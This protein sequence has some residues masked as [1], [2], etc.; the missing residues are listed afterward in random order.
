MGDSNNENVLFCCFGTGLLTVRGGIFLMSGGIVGCVT[1][2][3]W[4]T[5]GLP[6]PAVALGESRRTGTARSPSSVACSGSRWQP[7]PPS[8]T[9]ESALWVF[10]CGCE[11][12]SSE[13]KGDG[14]ML[15][16]LSLGMIGGLESST[17]V[18]VS[19]VS[20]S[21]QCPSLSPSLTLGPATLF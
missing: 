14:S 15:I 12:L 2:G 16:S 3:A 18:S 5:S 4:S 10:N 6:I 9:L 8:S 21:S 17:D 19:L 1:V 13:E 7:S 11:E 20:V